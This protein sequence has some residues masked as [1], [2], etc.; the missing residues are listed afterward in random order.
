[1]VDDYLV[2]TSSSRAVSSTSTRDWLEAVVA[3][4][5]PHCLKK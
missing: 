5:G 1:M 4:P 3:D 2:G